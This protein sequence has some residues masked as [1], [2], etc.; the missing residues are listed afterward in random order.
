MRIS[1]IFIFLLTGLIS[2]AQDF[3]TVILVRHAEKDMTASTNNPDLSPE[4]QERAKALSHVLANM[5]ISAVY[6]T[7]YLRTRNTVQGIAAIK[8]LEIHEYA[9]FDED[10]IL[11]IIESN[12]G[13][14]I[15]F[16]GHSNTVPAMLNL[17]T[18]TKDYPVLSDNDYDNLFI[19]MLHGDDVQV[20]PLQYG[21]SDSAGN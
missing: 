5:D 2:S 4:G 16:S 20:F 19:V 11:K 12:H 6:S 1:L 17:L 14:T 21:A 8:N 7:P 18:R 13:K 10:A 9:P 15:L 3:T